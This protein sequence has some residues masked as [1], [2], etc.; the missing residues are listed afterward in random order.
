MKNPF[1]LKRIALLFLLTALTLLAYMIRYQSAYNASS[2]YIN[3]VSAMIDYLLTS[4]EKGG[5]TLYAIIIF[6]IDR[7]VFRA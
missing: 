5:Q 2:R 4:L 1:W 3:V 6:W 7:C